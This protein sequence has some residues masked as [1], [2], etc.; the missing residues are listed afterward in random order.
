MQ[1]IL[2]NQP[3]PDPKKQLPII[4]ILGFLVLVVIAPVLWIALRAP[5]ASPSRT[6][7]P[8]LSTKM[9]SEEQA[10]AKSIHIENI[11]LSRAENFIH[12]EVTILDADAV[13]AG[14]QSVAGLAVTVEFFDDMHQVVLR[15]TRGV[16]GTPPVVLTPG[17]KRSFSIS[18]DR[19]PASWNLQ[20]PSVRVTSLQ[21]ATVK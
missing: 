3:D 20:L 6:A 12:Q 9:S 13:N 14:Q 16:L 10:Y 2:H 17:Q 4:P 18:F 15:E 5:E 19:V 7:V 21:L 1:Q 11:V 8:G